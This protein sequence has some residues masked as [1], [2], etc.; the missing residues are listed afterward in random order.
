M[1]ATLLAVTVLP[2]ATILLAN[3]PVAL[4]ESIVTV[5]PLCTPTNDAE[6]REIVAATP[7]SYSVFVAVIPV[8]VS[9]FVATTKD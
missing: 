1:S 2:V 9:A 7:R 5:S 8:M 4:D 3:E 6:E